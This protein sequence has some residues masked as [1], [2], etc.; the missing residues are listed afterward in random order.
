MQR[1][2]GYCAI[3]ILLLYVSEF[4]VYVFVLPYKSMMPITPVAPLT[5]MD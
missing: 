3:D 5:N 1:D 2:R 4:S